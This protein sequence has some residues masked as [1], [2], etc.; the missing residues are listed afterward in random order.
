LPSVVYGVVKEFSK[1]SEEI[2][3]LV[4]VLLNAISQAIKVRTEVSELE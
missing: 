3:W 1:S 4:E 2:E